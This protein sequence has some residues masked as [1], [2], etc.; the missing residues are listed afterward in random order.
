MGLVGCCL[1]LVM[2]LRMRLGGGVRLRL[3]L[4]LRLGFKLFLGLVL[5]L[6]SGRLLRSLGYESFHSV[7]DVAELLPCLAGEKGYVDDDG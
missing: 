7:Q 6:V 2:V 5:G 1:G 4:G 3:R